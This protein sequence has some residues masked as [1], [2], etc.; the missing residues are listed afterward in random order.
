MV[1]LKNIVPQRQ[2]F[3]KIVVGMMVKKHEI[4][5]KNPL[6][7]HAPFTRMEKYATIPV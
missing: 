6:F 7:G 4:T 5:V 3:V 1:F 2:T